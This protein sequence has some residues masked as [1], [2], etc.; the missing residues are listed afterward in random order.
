MVYVEAGFELREP[1]KDADSAT[2]QGQRQ[3][4]L[5]HGSLHVFTMTR[6]LKG[7]ILNLETIRLLSKP[8][9]KPEEHQEQ[10]QEQ[11]Q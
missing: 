10:E 11:E 7:F 8:F 6:D 5:R 4:F 1:E 3:I 9:V 2:P